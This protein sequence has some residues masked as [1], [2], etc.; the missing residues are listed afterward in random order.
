VGEEN[1]CQLLL[2]DLY[3]S[4]EGNIE[5]RD[6]MT[7]IRLLSEWSRRPNLSLR[8]TLI[9]LKG[10]KIVDLGEEDSSFHNVKREEMEDSY[11]PSISST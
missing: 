2:E 6:N 4:D 3:S 8:Y 10:L 9:Q 1:L 7:A 11:V 5:E